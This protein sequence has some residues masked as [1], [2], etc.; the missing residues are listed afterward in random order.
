MSLST[1]A[2]S[3]VDGMEN[4]S[5]PS[6]ARRVS[7]VDLSDLRDDIVQRHCD[8]DG[9]CGITS[10]GNGYPEEVFAHMEVT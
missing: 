10:N 7:I 9:K 6:L 5:F 4:I 8:K 2:R 3:R 1:F